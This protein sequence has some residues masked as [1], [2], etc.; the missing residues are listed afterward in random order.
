ML[1]ANV[2]PFAAAAKTKKN[3]MEDVH[4]AATWMLRRWLCINCKCEG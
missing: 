1:D 2:M 4:G 3:A